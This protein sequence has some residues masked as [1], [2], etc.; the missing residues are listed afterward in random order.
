MATSASA[1]ARPCTKTCTSRRWSISSSSTAASPAIA[2]C[3]RGISCRT[4]GAEQARPNWSWKSA[5]GSS[6]S[7]PSTTR[8]AR[9]KT[10]KAQLT[11]DRIAEEVDRLGGMRFD[12]CVEAGRA[13]RSGTAVDGKD[14]GLVLSAGQHA[15]E[16]S[17]VVGV[18]RAA[19]SLKARG[20]K[21]ALFPQE[22]PDGYA[23]HRALRLHNPRHMHHAAR[24]SALGDD[25]AY[26]D[27]RT[28]AR[29]CRQVGGPP[30]RERSPAS[31]FTATRRMNGRVPIQDTC[32][33]IRSCGWCRAASS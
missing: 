24:F 31:I 9:W 22:N 27:R 20:V 25:I 29:A 23:L 26:R 1:R 11:P 17:G 3:S 5:R 18:L 32:R 8:R 14:L 30:S 33:A 16:T 12:G 10:R 21:F 15:N 4:S 7:L 28:V 2:P 6:R 13:G 19:A